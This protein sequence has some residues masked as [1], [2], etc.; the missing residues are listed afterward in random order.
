MYKNIRIVILVEI[1]KKI[2]KKKK[3]KM[4]AF[5]VY[6]LVLFKLFPEMARQYDK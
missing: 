5:L 1:N 4:H 2:W 3:I 6:G